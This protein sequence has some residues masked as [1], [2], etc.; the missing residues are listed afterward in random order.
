[1]RPPAYLLLPI[2]GTLVLVAVVLGAWLWPEPAVPAHGLPPA[3]LAPAAVAPAPPPPALNPP[4][5]RSVVRTEPARPAQ[6]PPAVVPRPM[7]SEG[8]PSPPAPPPAPAPV[9]QAA[10]L[11][12]EKQAEVDQMWRTVK[13]RT[14]EHVLE[15]IQQLE[16]Q[17]D[18]AQAR[19]DQVEVDRLEQL[20][21]AQREGVEELRGMR[22]PKSYPSRFAPGVPVEPPRQ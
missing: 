12:P 16:R 8:V 22:P 9:D 10:E 2:L 1:M 4:P 5:P 7:E 19:G 14:A 20:I 11:T 21:T 6:P 15:Q 3:Q 17:R 13:E 18:E